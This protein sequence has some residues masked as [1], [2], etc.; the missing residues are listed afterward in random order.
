MNETERGIYLFRVRKLLHLTGKEWTEAP[1]LEQIGVLIGQYRND[2]TDRWHSLWAFL[3]D[4]VASG[5]LRMDGPP[6]EKLVRVTG[7]QVPWF[8]INPGTPFLGWVRQHG[9]AREPLAAYRHTGKRQS[10][11]PPPAPRP[12]PG[13]CKAGNCPSCWPRGLL[14]G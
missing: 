6:M 9:G 3:N 2:R 8:K 11:S 7:Q 13:C 1:T 14:P 12:W 10:R 4:A 5:A